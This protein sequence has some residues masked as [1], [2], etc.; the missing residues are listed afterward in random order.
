M[1]VNTLPL[2][3]LHVFG[4]SSIRLSIIINFELSQFVY[5]LVYKEYI[6]EQIV[7]VVLILAFRIRIIRLLFA[8]VVRFLACICC[9]R[10]TFGSNCGLLMTK[11]GAVVSDLC[12]VDLRRVINAYISMSE[13]NGIRGKLLSLVRE[14]L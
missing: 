6:V 14:V 1:G 8:E 11:Y 7:F 12:D 5:V 9:L 13:S 10:T 4:E 2:E 3:R